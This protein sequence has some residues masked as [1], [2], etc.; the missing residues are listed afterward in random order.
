MA[1]KIP[2]TAAVQVGVEAIDEQH[3]ELFDRINA[4]FEGLQGSAGRA[5]VARTIGFLRGYTLRHFRD[6][7]KLQRLTGYPGYPQHKTEHDTFEARLKTLSDQFKREGAS[8]EFLEQFEAL[9][10]RWLTNHI[11]VRDRDIARHLEEKGFDP[12]TIHLN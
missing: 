10:V 9:T 5:E 8:P 1:Q 7:E 2:W 12:H 6:E 11:Q 4:C 3:K